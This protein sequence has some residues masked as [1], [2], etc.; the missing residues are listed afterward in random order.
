[1]RPTWELTCIDLSPNMLKVGAEN[2]SEAGFRSQIKLELIDA[3]AMPYPDSYFDMVISNSIIHH[4]PDPL[5]FLQEVKRVL[6]PQGAIF[7]RDLL[8][9]EKA[10]I[11][12]N[13]VNL[14]AGD[15]N[16]HQKQ[17]FSD[18]LQAAFTLDEVEEMIQNAGLDGL[19]IY[20][21]SDRHWT[22]ER[23]WTGLTQPQYV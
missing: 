14:Y 20:E 5:P 6:K 8:R 2:V 11:R 17:L 4:L 7:L 12:D 16:A 22:A 10:E 13:L 15:C 9:P 21:S 1:M 19:R 3:K 18:S 23:A